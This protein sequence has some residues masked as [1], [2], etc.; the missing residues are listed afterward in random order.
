MITIVQQL[1]IS[2]SVKEQVTDTSI[3]V[4][5]TPEK[6]TRVHTENSSIDSTPNEYLNTTSDRQLINNESNVVNVSINGNN[7][8]VESFVS[9]S[10]EEE[11]QKD[12]EK[13]GGESYTPSVGS[14]S[15]KSES[16]LKE[17]PLSDEQHLNQTNSEQQQQHTNQL[18]TISEKLTSATPVTNNDLK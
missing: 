15:A 1:P 4:S 11:E 6:N 16:I 17:S 7:M 8:E 2:S 9:K 3:V 10:T 13:I 18:L 14:N 5:L 12:I